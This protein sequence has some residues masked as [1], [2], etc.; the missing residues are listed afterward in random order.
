MNDKTHVTE[1]KTNEM[2]HDDPVMGVTIK[3]MTILIPKSKIG[4]SFIQIIKTVKIEAL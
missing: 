2:L 3:S 4:N 1:W